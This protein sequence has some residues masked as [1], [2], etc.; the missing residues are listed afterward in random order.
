M[1][2]WP[3]SRRP[4]HIPA[5]FTHLAREVDEI[6]V[7]RAS[8]CVP[9]VVAPRQ[10]RHATTIDAANNCVVRHQL[11]VLVHRPSVPRLS[12]ATPIQ[13]PCADHVSLSGLRGL[14]HFRAGGRTPSLAVPQREAKNRVAVQN[15]SRRAIVLW[16]CVWGKA[17]L[18]L[19]APDYTCNICSIL[20]T[21]SVLHILY[22]RNYIFYI[23]YTILYIT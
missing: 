17:C 6:R 7:C 5:A 12:L 21:Y 19:A 14:I 4:L 15:Y 18:K 1:P 13:A 10:S 22:F 2:L 20:I 11:D 3:T 8:G 9:V 23:T 16:S